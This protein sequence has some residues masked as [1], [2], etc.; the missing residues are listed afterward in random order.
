MSD[1][2]ADTPTQ[3]DIPKVSP[4]EVTHNEA[5]RRYELAVGGVVAFAE[6]NRLSR[7][8]MLT[9]TEVPEALEGRGVGSTLARGVLE[10]ARAQGLEVI[11]LCP[12]MAAFIRRH[13]EYLDLVSA[14]SRRQ[15]LGG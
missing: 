15:V 13:P 9:H 14:V 7:A 1:T 2:P 3:T 6:Y 11:P 12:F 5:R 8:L 4:D 10:D